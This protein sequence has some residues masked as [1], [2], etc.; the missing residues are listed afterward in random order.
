MKKFLGFTEQGF[1]VVSLL[2]YSGAL[3]TLI[4][5][6]GIN[7]GEAGEEY[8]LLLNQ[9]LFRLIYLVTFLLLLL[10]W[11]KVIYLL[12]KDRFI[13]I[14]VGFA[15]VSVLWSS[16]PGTTLRSGICLIGSS[17][18]G[19]YFATRYS[20]KQQV[21]L[22]GWMFGISIVLSLVFALALPQY[23]IM[24]GIHAG[25][26]RGIYTHKNSLG[27][28]M[29]VS[30]I[31]FLLLAID[32]QKNR[33]L[34]W[35]GFSL[36]LTLILLSRSSSSAINVVILIALFLVLRTLRWRYKLMIPAFLAVMIIGGSLCLCFTANADIIL[37]S[38]FGKNSELS[39]RS[40]L[41]SVVL[42]MI[43]K[44]PWLGYGLS[45]FWL[46]RYGNSAEVWSETGWAVPHAHNG[47]LD[48]GLD[49]GV[50]GIALFLLGFGTSL[51]RGLGW[52]RLNRNSYSF[53][54]LMF[55]TNLVLA[56][57]TESSLLVSRNE[58]FWVLYVAVAFS[59]LTLPEQ[60]TKML[61]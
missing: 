39:G 58:L 28:H 42:E 46:G 54:P 20:M 13:W 26:W 2:L 41:W 36:S 8:D 10:R 43:E 50:L 19:V 4:L 15:V 30:T 3:L 17:M 57:L 9:L 21:Q 40:D 14:F 48:L 53:W 25:D 60:Q 49:L 56:N 11:K 59:V 23:G 51:V 45:G 12:S 5:S 32:K 6:G 27:K 34:L 38:L 1:T 44:R 31:I 33:W 55:M 37:R 16:I 47:L 61:V 18:F 29:V 24:G 7:E 22:L 52:V 35:C